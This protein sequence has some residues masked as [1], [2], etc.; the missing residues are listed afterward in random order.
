[1]TPSPAPSSAKLPGSARCVSCQAYSPSRRLRGRS[2]P[3]RLASPRAC[4]CRLTCERS[5]KGRASRVGF[6]GHEPDRD[7]R[8]RRRGPQVQPLHRRC[9]VTHPRPQPHS[10]RREKERAKYVAARD[11]A[12]L[13]V[14]LDHGK[15]ATFP[16]IQKPCAEIRRGLRMTCWPRA[17]AVALGIDGLGVDFAFSGC[18]PRCADARPR[19]AG[20]ADVVHG[21]DASS[22]CSLR[23]WTQFSQRCARGQAARR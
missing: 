4:A 21:F 5:S 2:S 11:Q 18:R 10:T 9:R 16:I 14:Q 6:R 8:P 3:S 15:L 13:D 19:H 17:S 23:T 7:C 1:M 12:R 20:V 22:I